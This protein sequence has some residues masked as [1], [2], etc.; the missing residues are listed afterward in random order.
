MNTFIEQAVAKVWTDF[1]ISHEKLI[2]EV[3]KHVKGS[4]FLSEQDVEKVRQAAILR[5]NPI[6]EVMSDH[7]SEYRELVTSHLGVIMTVQLKKVIDARLG[8]LGFLTDEKNLK[9]LEPKSKINALTQKLAE[10]DKKQDNLQLQL[11]EVKK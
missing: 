8:E 6:I 11:K 9:Q 2:A 3:I 10:M 1:T 7:F 5:L 4:V